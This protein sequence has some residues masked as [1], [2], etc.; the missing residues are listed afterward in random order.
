V[1]GAVTDGQGKTT[2]GKS[3]EQ[4]KNKIDNLKKRYKV[5]CQRLASSGAGA[6]SHWPWFKK[7][8]QIVG[9]SASPAS[10]KPLA[11]AEDEKPRQQQQQHGS[12][13]WPVFTFLLD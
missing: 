4:C 10:S 7:M 11:V 5:E 1:A 2:G 6:V 13:R 8:E 12:K 9:N 3:V